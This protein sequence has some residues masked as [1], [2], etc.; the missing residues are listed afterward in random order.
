MWSRWGRAWDGVGVG[1]QRAGPVEGAG[2]AG[3]EPCR[4]AACERGG[5]FGEQA[6]AVRGVDPGERRSWDRGAV[7][8][9]GR[10]IERWDPGKGWDLGRDGAL[11]GRGL[12]MYRDETFRD[13]TVG[14]SGSPRS[15][16]GPWGGLALESPDSPP[17]RTWPWAQ[18]QRVRR[19]RMP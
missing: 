11:R 8:G 13:L 3:E 15:C 16:Q 14:R 5:A 9:R 1:P 7:Y 4:G 17:R 19:S 2:S 6:G 12:L 10:S 18:T